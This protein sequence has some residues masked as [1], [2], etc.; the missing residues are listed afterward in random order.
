MVDVEQLKAQ[1]PGTIE[2]VWQLTYEK[3]ENGDIH[4]GAELRLDGDGALAT[5]VLKATGRKLYNAHLDRTIPNGHFNYF[6]ITEVRES[7]NLV[8]GIKI[9]AAE[10]PDQPDATPVM[11]RTHGQDLA[12]VGLS[13]FLGGVLLGRLFKR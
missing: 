1:Y 11:G 3:N 8:T 9:A 6:V 12:L 4:E 5:P 7:D 13:A 10:I 2:R